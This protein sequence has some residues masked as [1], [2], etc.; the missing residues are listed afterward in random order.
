MPTDTFN[1]MKKPISIES[2]VGGD[3]DLK[4]LSERTVNLLPMLVASRA[5][6]ICSKPGGSKLITHQSNGAK[7]RLTSNSRR[8]F[9]FWAGA[10]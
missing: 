8:L 5:K 1:Q 2:S 3:D 9:P 10:S 7:Q 6:A 4:M